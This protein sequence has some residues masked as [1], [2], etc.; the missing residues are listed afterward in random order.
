[1]DFAIKKGTP[2][3]I[4]YVKSRINGR[5]D[6]EVQQAF[7]RLSIVL[8][9]YLYF[10]FE[11]SEVVPVLEKQVHLLGIGLTLISLSLLLGAIHDAGISERRRILGMLHDFTV[12][13]YILSISGE[14]GAPV[15]ATY[16]W[17]SLGNGFRYGIRYLLASTVASAVGFI[18]VYRYNVFWQSH[19]P[20]WW[21]IWLTLIVVPLYASSLLKQLH[22]AVRREKEANQAKSNFLAT[23]SHEL[24]TP[25]NGVI[26]GSEL[27]ANTQ[28]NAEQKEYTQIIHASAHALLDLIDNVLDIARIETGMLSK[29]IED[30]DLHRVVNGTIAIM[31][32]QARGKG[33]T[34]AAHVAPQTPYQLRGDARHLRQ[35]LINLLGNAIK[36]TLQG[37][38][39]LYVRP[40]GSGKSPRLRFE[41]VDTGI[42]IAEEAQARIFERFTQADSSI[43]RRYGGSGLGT[44]IA[45]QLVMEVLG[46]EIGLDSRLGAGSTFW[47]ELPFD[48][49]ASPQTEPSVHFDSPMR[50]AI[51]GSPEFHNQLQIIVRGWGAETLLVGSTQLAEQLPTFVQS[52]SLPRAIVVERAALA[53]DPIDFL[54][55]LPSQSEVGSVPVI[56]I[57][58]SGQRVSDQDSQRLKAGFASILSLPVNTTL[59]FN[60]LHAATSQ[61][62]PHNVISL[63]ERFLAK[64]EQAGKLRI[65]IAEDNP[66]NQRVIRNLLE[67][68]GHQVYLARDG[69]EALTMLE[70][71]EEGLDLAIIDMH[72][73]H[74]SGLEVVQRWRFMEKTRLPIIM[75]TADARVEAEHASLEA[76]ADA[77][78]TKPLSRKALFEE[79]ARLTHNKKYFASPVNDGDS[80]K[81]EMLD[82]AVLDELAQFGG[83]E[84]IRELVTSFN[85]DSWRALNEVE[86][87]LAHQDYRL[88]HDQLHMLKGGACDVGAHQLAKLCSEAESI[89]PY[90]IA[91]PTTRM[92][93]D[94]IKFVLESTQAALSKYL[95]RSLV[96]ERV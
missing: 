57:E 84:F 64:A 53:G 89:K 48:L 44:T 93:L 80:I 58:P 63:A 40:V 59:L 70:T 49:R 45:K 32:A 4:R 72:M 9:F 42:G 68:S 82:E 35:V 33:L 7:I 62:L 1:M 79:I 54:G 74:L 16:L 50:I 83:Y 11:W 14:A 28:L 91:Q 52:G 34:L 96:I 13:T 88:W 30:F 29:S 39:D 76:E 8:A 56:L 90:E 3:W 24:R 66:V 51:V 18:I 37:R 86:S 92:R 36:F 78:L 67:H 41:V 27:L 22:G 61:D 26:G 65:L 81:N 95:D 38:V 69:D 87:A 17:V 20:L 15:V 94:A 10:L 77:F 85:E 19:T 2:K 46:G 25:L 60:A 73:P 6:T 71:H 55:H 43:T 21:S 31:E 23:M 12:A 47:F 5:P 75:L